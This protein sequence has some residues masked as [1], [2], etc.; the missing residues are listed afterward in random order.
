MEK[1]PSKQDKLTQKEKSLE[2]V[3]NNR[4]PSILTTAS[5]LPM[6]KKRQSSET[7][8]FG[9]V[10]SLSPDVHMPSDHRSPSTAGT[11]QLMSPINSITPSSVHS[12]EE[13]TPVGSRYQ[14]KTK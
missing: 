12:K 7:I 8:A 3:S 11:P 2:R 1:M 5:S 13:F 4:I 9:E 10:A 6:M 14:S